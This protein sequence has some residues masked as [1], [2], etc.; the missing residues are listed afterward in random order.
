[1]WPWGYF[2]KRREEKLRRQRELERRRKEL[3][4]E[5]MRLV[6]ENSDFRTFLEYM[7]LAM[8][9]RD[10][11]SAAL[12]ETIAGYHLKEVVRK[13]GWDEEKFSMFFNEVEENSEFILNL[14]RG[15]G[16]IRREY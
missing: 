14:A 4:V 16:V 8:R 2:K 9:A 15:V 3:E 10:P 7:G 11:F 5:L 13:H 6:N 1:L 12:F